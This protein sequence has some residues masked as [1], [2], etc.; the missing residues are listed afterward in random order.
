MKS[1]LIKTLSCSMLLLS[2]GQVLADTQNNA[3]SADQAIKARMKMED[4]QEQLTH[5]SDFVPNKKGEMKGLLQAPLKTDDALPEAPP[6]TASGDSPKT[7][8]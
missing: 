6:A 1:T 4:Q 7:H 2:A 8:R 3:Q 5:A